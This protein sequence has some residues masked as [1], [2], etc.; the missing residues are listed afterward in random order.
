[1]AEKKV[2]SVAE[3]A[4]QLDV[5]E[6]TVHYWKNRFVQHLPSVGQGRQK[7]F[8]PEAVEIFA[9]IAEMLGAGHP[10]GEVMDVLA[11]QYPMTPSTV[12]ESVPTA[13]S[14]MSMEPVIQM[15]QTMG[16]EIARSLGDYLSK[17]MDPDMAQGQQDIMQLREE[18]DRNNALISAQYDEI[19]ELKRENSELRGKL[20]VMEQELVRLRKDSRELEKHLL[21]KIKKITS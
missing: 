15:A 3:I 12:V 14:A 13:M 2:L 11:Q 20:K 5:P 8:R 16:N 7:R 19:E 6:S 10:A 9:K 18:V 21:D 1:M 4:R 17:L